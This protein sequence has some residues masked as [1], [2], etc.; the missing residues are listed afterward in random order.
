MNQTS[1]SWS[2]ILQRWQ[3][4]SWRWRL[5]LSLQALGISLVAGSFALLW[6]SV[7]NSHLFLSNRQVNAPTD[8][9]TGS[10]PDLLNGSQLFTPRGVG[11]VMV[12]VAGAV[13]KPG[14]Y[15]LASNLVIAD[16]ITAAGGW[17]D[18]A[19]HNYILHHL[20]LAERLQDS[21]KIYVPLVGEYQVDGR[22]AGNSSSGAP[23]SSVGNSPG[24]EA[25]T[26]PPD[27][28]DPSQLN[29][30]EPK[31]SINTASQAELDAL[32]DIGEKRAQEIIA[33][34]PYTTLSELVSK[35]ALSEAV[36]LKLQSQLTL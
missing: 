25:T 24:N 20:N 29:S 8:S 27:S 15:Q 9:L 16:A 35:Q 7:N 28:V 5:A 19:D 31:L 26:T 34:R 30:N 13:V 22:L 33:G 32:P 21:Q 6:L 23:G 11:Q 18:R 4:L 17:S 12:E 3:S 36:F 2:K 1:S 10:P 14:V